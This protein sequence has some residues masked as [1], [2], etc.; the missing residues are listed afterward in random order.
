[1]HA[2]KNHLLSISDIEFDVIYY[3]KWSAFLGIS[4]PVKNYDNFT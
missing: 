1:M 2:E 3:V 4:A